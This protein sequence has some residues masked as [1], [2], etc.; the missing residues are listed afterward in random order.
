MVSIICKAGTAFLITLLVTAGAQAQSVAMVTDV[1]GK[2]TQ[3]GQNVSILSELAAD[4]RVQ[5]DPGS[6][7]TAIY[8]QSGD[9]YAF[10]GPAQI[11]F[12]SSEPHVMSGAKPQKRANPLGKGVTIRPVAV[13][14]AAFVMRSGRT[15]ERVKLLTLSGTR[16][17]DASP[18]FR[19]QEVGPDAKYRF[20]LT[21]DAG[22]AVHET[23]VEG[24][25]LKLPDSVR[26]REGA[27]YTWD[28]SARLAGGRRY[29]GAGDF[30]VASADLRSQVDAL[31]PRQGAPVSQRVA[32][33]VWLEQMEFRDEAR[34]Y[35]KALAA[36]R[37]EDAKLKTLAAE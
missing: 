20:E 35:W 21:D 10:N 15:S 14:Q 5:L 11:Q 25:S 19:W 8:I 2:V 36:E 37:P 13:T 23:V 18:E 22:K 34:K 28:L 31:R 4:A 30:T 7:L 12:R 3:S 24:G 16:T 27:S 9:E 33:A 29:V 17:L 32:F 26:L 1:S 6:R